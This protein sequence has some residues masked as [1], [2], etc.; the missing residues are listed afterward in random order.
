MEQIGW[1]LEWSPVMGCC[2]LYSSINHLHNKNS[3]CNVTEKQMVLCVNTWIRYLS[4]YISSKNGEI[5]MKKTK[6]ILIALFTLLICVGSLS[7]SV[8]AN[9]YD[10]ENNRSY[11][12]TINEYDMIVQLAKES[13]ISLRNKGVDD[14]EI[15]RIKNYKETYDNHI[16][17]LNMLD[18]KALMSNGY[19]SDQI[20]LIRNF[21]GSDADMRALSATL[22]LTTST[23]TFNYDGDYT[24]GKLSYSWNWSSVPAFKMK[25]MVAVSWNDWI[26]T[27]N[28]STVKYYGINSG[29]YYTQESATFTQDGNGTEGAGHKFNM[30]KSDNYYYAKKGSGSF[31]V[32]SDVHARKDFAYYI[33]YGHSQLLASISFS[34]GIGGGDASISFSIGTVI[35]DSNHDVIIAS[36]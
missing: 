2:I 13:E 20:K 33:A 18:D 10:N 6:M 14:T 8:F 27:N 34:V 5:Q 28:S 29:A 25:D 23:N 36:T 30:S 22:S 31:S 4:S 26:V 3:S 32:R 19:T 21:N 17:Y 1:F 9:E 15:L 35:M 24:R 7:M 12:T 11:T 16:R